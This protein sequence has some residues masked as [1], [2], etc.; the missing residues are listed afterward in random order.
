MRKWLAYVIPNLLWVEKFKENQSEELVMLLAEK[1][2]PPTKEGEP[3]PWTVRL[4]F[5]L[6][7]NSYVAVMKNTGFLHQVEFL[8]EES[9]KYVGVGDLFV[10]KAGTKTMGELILQAGPIPEEHGTAHFLSASAA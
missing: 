5:P 8:V 6:L 7:E 3:G 1:I 4:N 9:A 2:S 10:L